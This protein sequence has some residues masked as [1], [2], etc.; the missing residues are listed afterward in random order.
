MSKETERNIDIICE[1]MASI[2][3]GKNRKYGDSALNPI[4]VFS[5]SD[6]TTSLLVRA[7]DKL[8]R[9]NNNND[10]DPDDL[11]DLIGYSMLIAISRGLAGY[12]PGS[13]KLTKNVECPHCEAINILSQLANGN[14]FCNICGIMFDLDKIK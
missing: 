13:D 8:S 14:V 12:T 2:L 10:L 7:D 6:N 11:F 5:K 1:N 9:I 4:R 3:K